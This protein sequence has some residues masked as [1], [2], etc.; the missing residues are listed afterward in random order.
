M[1]DKEKIDSEYAEAVWSM[2]NSVD[3]DINSQQRS[4]RE[5]LLNEWDEEQAR[6]IASEL[7]I[8]LTD[9]HLQVVQSLREHYRE[10]GESKSG[11]QLTDMLNNVFA[12]QGGKKYLHRL[13]PEGPVSQGMHIAGLPLPANTEDA[14]FGTA[15]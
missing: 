11:Q 8:E 10:H 4:N 14:G 5:K 9:A 7:G 13:F 3:T 6:K 15:R 2:D 1:I 12:S